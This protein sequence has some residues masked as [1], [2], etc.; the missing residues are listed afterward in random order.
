MPP[1]TS[2]T[3][4]RHKVRW[5]GFDKLGEVGRAWLFTVGALSLLVLT[6]CPSRR[7]ALTVAPDSIR[8]AEPLETLAS[9]YRS[10]AAYEMLA[11]GV[12][13]RVLVYRDYDKDHRIV[14][15]RR[16]GDVYHRYG[17]EFNLLGFSEPAPSESCGGCIRTV[18]RDTGSAERLVLTAEGV[19]LVPEEGEWVQMH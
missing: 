18:H 16:S 5:G 2:G 8:A 10:I 12:E 13:F 17:A 7:D 14:V 19:D 6:A 4:R 1:L 15:Y 3:F 9:N 11:D